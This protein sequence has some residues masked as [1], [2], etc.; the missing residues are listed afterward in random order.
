M[1]VEVSQTKITSHLSATTHL[2]NG[3]RTIW[4]SQHCFSKRTAARTAVVHI[5]FL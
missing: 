1:V 4:S 2:R 3:S 5:D